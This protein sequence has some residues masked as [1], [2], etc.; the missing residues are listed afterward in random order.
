MADDLKVRRAEAGA[1]KMRSFT[2]VAYAA[3]SWQRERHVVARPE[4]TTRGFD[5]R[6]VVTSLKGGTA[7]RPLPP[8]SRPGSP[9][10]CGR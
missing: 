6:Y 3:K 9:R 4:A 1:E 8:G 7:A 2:A 10:P 5:A